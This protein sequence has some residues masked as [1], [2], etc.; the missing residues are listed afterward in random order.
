METMSQSSLSGIRGN[1]G[2]PFSDGAISQRDFGG[3][4]YD[5]GEDEDE[6]DLYDK[7][8]PEDDLDEMPEGEEDIQQQYSQMPHVQNPAMGSRFGRKISVDMS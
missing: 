5:S 4:L 3:S 1:A 8:I 6:D 7:E 2:A